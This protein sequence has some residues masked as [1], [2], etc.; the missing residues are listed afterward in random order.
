M[1]GRNVRGVAKSTA[2]LIVLVIILAVIAAAEPAFL[3]AQT[4]TQTVATTV[5]ETAGATT[6]TKTIT[7]ATGAETVTVTE[8]ETVIET[9]TETVTAP[10]PEKTIWETIVE[11]GYIIVGTSPDWPP[12]EYLDPETGELTGYEV[13]LM[14]MIA[15]ELGI[16]VE[17]KTMD[18]ATIIVAVQNREIDLGVSGFSITPERLEV[19]QYTIYHTVTEVQLIM[20]KDRA[21]ELGIEKLEELADVA[22]YGLVVGTG[23]GTTQEAELMELV[24]QGI[25]SP[26]A[27]KSYPDFG[28]ALED[29][30]LGRIDALYAETPITTW[31]M[32][33]EETPMTVV[34]SRPYWPVAFVAH[35]DADQ[36]VA[37][38][39]GA[40]ATLIAEGKVA[41]LYKKW[42]PTA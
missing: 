9:T 22:D 7:A 38:I 24:N 33:T 6:V 37:K 39:N 36:L 23:S 11:R 19:I 15:D 3:P 5:T 30:K 42:S 8:T 1:Y 14:E 25:L 20:L 4:V 10:K 41:E 18:F 16:D 2:V 35:Q 12:F 27:L 13:E 34:Y 28:A 21:E 26:D 17:W 32:M 40:L 29:L 31:W